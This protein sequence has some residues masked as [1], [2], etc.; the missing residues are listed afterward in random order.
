MTRTPRLPPR[1]DRLVSSEV[2]LVFSSGDDQFIIY[3]KGN[4][5]TQDSGT[6]HVAVTEGEL[7]FGF[8]RGRGKYKLKEIIPCNPSDSDVVTIF[9]GRFEETY[10]LHRSAETFPEDLQPRRVAASLYDARR[11]RIS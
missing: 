3:A 11:E 4:Q 5:Q 7:R 10:I 8:Q 1:L 6:V 9:R 2:G